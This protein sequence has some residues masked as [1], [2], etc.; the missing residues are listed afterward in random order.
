MH[1]LTLQTM[2]DRSARRLAGCLGLTAEYL[3]LLKM[4]LRLPGI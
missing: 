2:E 4:S 1:A 3:P